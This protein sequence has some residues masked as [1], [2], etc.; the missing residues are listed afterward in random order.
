QALALP[1][2]DGYVGALRRLARED[3]RDVPVLLDRL[4]VSALIEGRSC[5]RFA[6][7]ADRL[8]EADLRDFYGTL[9]QSEARHFRLFCR[10]AEERFGLAESR[11]RLRVLA[12]REALVADQLPLGPTVHG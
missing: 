3:H 8:R 1:A 12:E 7:L 11:G 6:V 9:M 4:L 5:E 2:A 10:L